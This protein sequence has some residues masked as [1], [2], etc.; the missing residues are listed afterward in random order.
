MK[1]PQWL[2]GSMKRPV[3]LVKLSWAEHLYIIAKA[4]DRAK[5]I[6]GDSGWF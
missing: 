3:K 6:E 5:S 4:F 1:K 2:L